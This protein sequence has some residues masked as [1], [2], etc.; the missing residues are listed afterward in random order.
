MRFVFPYRCKAPRAICIQPERSTSVAQTSNGWCMPTYI[1][2][3]REKMCSPMTYSSRL[4]TDTKACNAIMWD[5][6]LQ[7]LYCTVLYRSAPL[8]TVLYVKGCM[9]LIVVRVLLLL[10]LPVLLSLITRYGHQNPPEHWSL[11]T[12]SMLCKTNNMCLLIW[13]RLR[14]CVF[15]VGVYIT[16]KSL[17]R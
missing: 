13:G 1:F 8:Y 5:G 9:D 14:A 7:V 11:Y 6:N 10:L 4:T 15:D 16:I 17:T 2:R 3:I 12:C